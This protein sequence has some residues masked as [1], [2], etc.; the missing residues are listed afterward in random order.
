MSL[1]NEDTTLIDAFLEHWSIKSIQ[2]LNDWSF[3]QCLEF[4]ERDDIKEF[5]EARSK[6]LEKMYSR[7]PKAL[8][9]QIVMN[10]VDHVLTNDKSATELAKVMDMFMVYHREA[11]PPSDNQFARS[12]AAALAP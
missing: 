11:P 2:S 5:I 7:M 12:I 9:L 10:R 3:D 6:R 1:S 8:Y 4:L